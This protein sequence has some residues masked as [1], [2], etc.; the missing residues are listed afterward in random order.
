MIIQQ[1]NNLHV[2]TTK[3]RLNFPVAA[4]TNVIRWENPNG[5]TASWAIQLGEQGEEQTE[6]VLLGTAV[7]AGTAGTLTGNTLYEHPTDTPLYSIK[8]DQVVFEVSTTGTAGTAT[9]ITNGTITYQPDQQYTSFDHTTGSASYAYKTYYR[10]SVLN[11]T[12]TESDWQTSGGFSFYSLGKIRQRIKDKLWDSSFLQDDQLIDDWINEYR[13]Q[14]INEVV[15]VNED[16]SMGTAEVAFGT[17]GLGTITTEDF[18][19]PRRVWITYNGSDKYQSTKMNVNDF[20]ADEQFSSVHPYHY[21][22]GDTVLGI[23][24]SDVGTAEI[25]YYKFGTTLVND[26]DELAQPMKTFTKGFVDY[27]LA[28]AFLKDG[29]VNEYRDKTTE[30]NAVKRDFVNKIVPRDKTGPTQIDIVEGISGNDDWG[31]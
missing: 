24:P 7:V 9:P 18:I 11:E 21:W 5:F 19:Q 25:V 20:Y 16:Y 23:K 8:Y 31:F 1:T 28:Q 12:T 2:N 10:N 27:A 22:Q 26:N 17:S 3:T 15:S 4:G 30:A 14:M 13:E 6:I 29:K